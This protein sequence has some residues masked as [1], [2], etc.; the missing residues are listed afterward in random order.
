MKTL[1]IRKKHRRHR[2][3]WARHV[4]LVSLVIAVLIFMVAAIVAKVKSGG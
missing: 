4:A 2:L 1:R 3:S